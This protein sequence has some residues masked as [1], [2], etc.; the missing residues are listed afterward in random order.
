MNE[1]ERAA[2]EWSRIHHEHGAMDRRLG[3]ADAMLHAAVDANPPRLVVELDEELA[4][5]CVQ[6]LVQMHCPVKA[7]QVRARIEEAKR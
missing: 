6:G 5:W 4:L 1:I 3:E 2:R 7:D